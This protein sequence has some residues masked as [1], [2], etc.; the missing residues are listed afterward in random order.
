VPFEILT[1]IRIESY[2]GKIVAQNLRIRVISIVVTASSA[3]FAL[4]PQRLGWALRT[5]I[6]FV[7]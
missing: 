3:G 1:S 7:K 4:A 2:V 6:T 5:I